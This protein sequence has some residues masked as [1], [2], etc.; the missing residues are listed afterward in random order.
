MKFNVLFQNLK[1]FSDNVN[2]HIN[3]DGIYMQGMDQSQCSCFESKLNSKWFDN[4][5]YDLEC[6]ESCQV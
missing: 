4:Y 2:L 5:D 1:A 3:K 6:T